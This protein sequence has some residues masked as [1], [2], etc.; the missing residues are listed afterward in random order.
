MWRD[1]CSRSSVV[2]LAPPG[3]RPLLRWTRDVEVLRCHLDGRTFG[4]YL[5][6][7][8]PRGRP[9]PARSLWSACMA[10]SVEESVCQDG[11][12]GTDETRVKPSTS[13]DPTREQSD[14]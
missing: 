12:S 2:V 9:A 4:T 1:I 8:Q 13:M 11:D 3:S 5:W 10:T 7:C 14:P 6:F